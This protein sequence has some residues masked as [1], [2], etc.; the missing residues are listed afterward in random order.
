MSN[1]TNQEEVKIPELDSNSFDEGV[2]E[3]LCLVDFWAP[4]CGPCKLLTPSIKQLMVEMPDIK[5]FKLNVDKAQ[6]ISMRFGVM[7]IPTI[8]IFKDGK[9][10]DTTVGVIPKKAIRAKIEAQQ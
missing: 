5:F 6:D 9:A 2:A 1:D 7:S 10:V 4:W 8:I 3:G